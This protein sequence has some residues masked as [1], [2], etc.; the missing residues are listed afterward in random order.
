MSLTGYLQA[1]YE[2][3]VDSN[4]DGAAVPDS[5]SL[6]RVRVRIKGDIL[7]WVG[8][9]IMFEVAGT[10]SPLRDGFLSFKLPHH[11]VRVGQQKTP[12]GYENP[13]S[14]TRLFTVNRAVVSDRLGRGNDLRDIGLGLY[15]GWK[16]PSAVGVEYAATLGNGSGANRREDT[17]FKNLWGRAGLT[18]RHETL[19]AA[20]ALGISAAT[21]DQLDPGPMSDDP[22]DDFDAGFHRLGL[23]VQ[24]DTRWALAVFEYIQGSTAITSAGAESDAHGWYVLLAGKTPWSLGPVFKAEQFDPDRDA[25]GDIQVRYTAGAYYDHGKAFRVLANYEIDRSDSRDDDSFLLFAQLIY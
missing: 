18:Y 17:E 5:F 12:F 2:N 16:L 19:G 25:A 20:G 3:G 21:G 14:S 13:L 22:S 15:S 9:T 6:K 1:L 10:Q 24:L 4:D 23:D 8:F 7:E 11:E